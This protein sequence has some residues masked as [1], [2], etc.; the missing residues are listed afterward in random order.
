MGRHVVVTFDDVNAAEQFVAALKVEGSV[1]FQGADEHFTHINPDE[2]R[3]SGIFA[4]PNS[5]CECPFEGKEFKYVRGAKYGLYVH[6]KC[7]K[8]DGGSIQSA[9][10]NLVYP[11]GTDVREVKVRLS[12]REGTKRWPE[13]SPADKGKPSHMVR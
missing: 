6:D 8:P 11:E 9:P 7:L 4:K 3:V 1:F 2:V 10:K 5:F 12:V 13:P